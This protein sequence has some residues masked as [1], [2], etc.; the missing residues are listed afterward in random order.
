VKAL[1]EFLHELGNI[2]NSVIQKLA[3]VLIIVLVITITIQVIF[4]SFFTSFSWTEEVSRFLLIYLSM[5]GSAMA[6]NKDRHISV[7]LFHDKLKEKTSCI[8]NII[9]NTLSLAF[10]VFL[11]NFSIELI[12]RQQYQVSGALQVPMQY[13]YMSIPISMSA[14]LVFCLG[15]ITYDLHKLLKM[16]EPQ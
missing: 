2:I 11:I 7:K 5:L 14:M 15:K 6:Y 12:R 9:I 8:I 16:G 13:I 10:F 3:I 1:S 4:R